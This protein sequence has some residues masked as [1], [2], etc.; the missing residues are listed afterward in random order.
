MGTLERLLESADQIKEDRIRKVFLT[1]IMLRVQALIE[2]AEQAL[3]SKELASIS[4]LKLS[5]ALL[6]SDLPLYMVPFAVED[7]S[8]N[9]PEDN[10]SRFNSLLTAISAY[11]EGFS[12]D[13]LIRRAVHLWRKLESR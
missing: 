10:G 1:D 2:N 8:F 12:A 5:Q 3:L 7:L 13:P 6:R 11:A 4:Y 9:K